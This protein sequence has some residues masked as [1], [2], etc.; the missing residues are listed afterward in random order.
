MQR[1][2]KRQLIELEQ[3]KRTNVADTK[4]KAAVKIKEGETKD[5]NAE[6]YENRE[7]LKGQFRLL[8][9]HQLPMHK[10]IE[11]FGGDPVVFYL[12]K[13]RNF[14]RKIEVSKVESDR[15]KEE[16]R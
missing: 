13:A 4:F 11:K 6:A 10:K 8:L 5:S 7:K 1:L 12:H 3:E 15:L 16:I 9:N 14:I 2:K